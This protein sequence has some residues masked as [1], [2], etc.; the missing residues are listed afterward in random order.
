MCTLGVEPKRV[1]V[2][3]TKELIYFILIA[4]L[5]RYLWNVP[6]ILIVTEA[7]VIDIAIKSCLLTDYSGRGQHGWRDFRD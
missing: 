7:L 1:D 6:F 5:R 4:T 3:M 2:G